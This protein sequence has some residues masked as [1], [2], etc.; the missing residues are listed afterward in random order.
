MGEPGAVSPGCGRM[1]PG[2]PGAVCP[3][4]PGAVGQERARGETGHGPGPCA[5]SR[6][7]GAV[8]PEP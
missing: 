5:R 3:G 2:E 4:E 6:E 1:S 8:S 7:P